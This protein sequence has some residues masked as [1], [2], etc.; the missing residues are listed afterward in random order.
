VDL[1]SLNYPKKS[2]RKHIIFPD[3]SVYLAEFFGILFGDGGI[4]NKW[5][6]VISLNSEA[7]LEYSEYVVKLIKFLFKIDVAVRKRPGQKCL[8]VVV[9]SISLIDFLLSKGAVYGNKVAK[10]F[11]IPKWILKNRDYHRCFV[12]GLMD[13]DGGFYTHSHRVGNRDYVNMGFCF[14]S[15]SLNMTASVAQIFRKYDINPHIERNGTRICLYSIKAMSE[16]LRVF[17]S[18]NPRL[19]KKF[20]QWRG[21]RVV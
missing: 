16:Y 11:D 6:F 2:H 14:A 5:Q 21:V 3:E 18:S 8:L 19:Y 20:E 4:G 15:F 17:G 9:S 12:R 10:G 13:T 1:N 7:D